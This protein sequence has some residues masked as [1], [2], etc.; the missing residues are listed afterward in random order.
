LQFLRQRHPQL[1]ASVRQQNI[2]QPLPHDFPKVDVAYSQAVIMHIHEGDAHLRALENMCRF[3][4]RAVVLMENWARHHF[5]DD[6]RRLHGEGL[7]P[8]WDRMNL[9]FRRLKGKP[10]ILIASPLELPF[11]PLTNYDCLL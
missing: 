2:T 6:L 11:E 7:N 3:S 8:Q 10:Y 1:N 9:Y 5:F 4:T